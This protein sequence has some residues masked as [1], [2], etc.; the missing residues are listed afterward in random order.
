MGCKGSTIIG[1]IMK[2]EK[3]INNNIVSSTDQDGNEVVVMGKG[4]GY[5]CVVGQPIKQEAIE[6]I[7]RIENH[8]N[9]ERFKVL[10]KNLPM[11]YIR[12]SNE[13]ISY[14]KSHLNIELSQTVYLTLTDHISFVIDQYKAGNTYPNM[15][16]EEIRRFY[17]EEYEVGKYALSL[18]YEKTDCKL[19]DNEASSIALHIVNA[20][21]DQRV[22]DTLTMINLMKDMLCMIEDDLEIED[23]DSL[24]KGW[25][26]INLKFLANRMLKIQPYENQPDP[27][28]TQFSR[29]HY[30]REYAL[31]DRIKQVISDKY[32]CE[33]TEEEKLYLVLHIGRIKELYLI[34]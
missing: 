25:L 5:K 34:R 22:K 18:I 8:D 27:Q 17:P 3:V 26:V 16:D 13:I 12:L 7:F 4:I 20:E 9:M 19:P 21:F 28:L 24:Y 32:E 1:A 33:M 15:L 23:K 10:L 6:K 30:T 2:V 31:A 11:E 14:A 29:L